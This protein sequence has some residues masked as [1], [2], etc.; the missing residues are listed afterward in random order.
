MSKADWH[1]VLLG[2]FAAGFMP[3]LTFGWCAKRLDRLQNQL[4][5][6]CNLL[7]MEMAEALGNKDRVNELLREQ[8]EADQAEQKRANRRRWIRWGMI[9]GAVALAWLWFTSQP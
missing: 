3:I 1:Y 4:E 5:A 9:I 2:L 7:R 6:V 8:R